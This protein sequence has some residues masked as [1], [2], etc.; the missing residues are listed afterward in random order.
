MCPFLGKV[1][2]DDRAAGSP[3]WVDFATFCDHGDRWLRRS[4][5]DNEL[6]SLAIA[7]VDDG[8]RDRMGREVLLQEAASILQG[9][10]QGDALLGRY[11]DDELLVLVARKPS[12]VSKAIERTR[13][14]LAV[15][16]FGRRSLE[17]TFCV[18]VASSRTCHESFS[19][20][21]TAATEA[22]TTARD[23]G[24]DR[25]FEYP[26]RPED[27]AEARTSAEEIAVSLRQ[28][29]KD[30]PATS[31]EFHASQLARIR[32]EPLE[33]P[34]LR[35]TLQDLMKCLESRNPYAGSHSQAVARLSRE[36]A[37]SMEIE[38]DEVLAVELAGLVHDVGKAGIPEAFLNRERI[39]TEPERNQLETGPRV[40]ARILESIPALSPVVPLVRHHAERWDGQGY[41]DRLKGEEI[42]LGAQIVSIC[43]AFDS[44]ASSRPYRGRWPKNE[45][46]EM[47]VRESER[48]WSAI[49][50]RAF[51]AL[52]AGPSKRYLQSRNAGATRLPPSGLK[53]NDVFPEERTGRNG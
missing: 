5:E 43:D 50:V 19:D 29:L 7:D 31:I 47:I 48:R 33:S 2:S 10:F 39:L 8:V 42:P 46:V 53:I 32:D 14:R 27:G 52:C 51:L 41:P 49:L 17:V 24:G 45:I 44:L 4:R 30:F 22:F 23:S 26:A 25:I 36:L 16:S 15:S 37:E 12:L 1:E 21:F 20:L 11:G 13:E 18:G 38:A 6:L 40:G 9:G 3:S 34:R 28:D 35:R